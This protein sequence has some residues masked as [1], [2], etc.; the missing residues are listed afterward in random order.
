M[1]GAAGLMFTVLNYLVNF[2]QYQTLVVGLGVIITAILNP[3]GAISVPIIALRERMARFTNQRTSAAL[4]PTGGALSARE[5]QA[6]T[7]VL[8]LQNFT[9]SYGGVPAVANVTLTVAPREILG[10]IGPNGAGKTSLLDG[11]TGFTVASGRVTLDA[12]AITNRPAYR[13]TRAG[14][15]RTFQ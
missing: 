11:I 1:F 5:L 6:E 10:L 8:D 4:K 12:E 2:N 14:L 15:A 13:I 3:D 7:A 9:V